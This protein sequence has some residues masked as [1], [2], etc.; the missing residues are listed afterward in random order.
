[1]INSIQN[2]EAVAGSDKKSPDTQCLLLIFDTRRMIY[3][4]HDLQTRIERYTLHITDI[5]G[6]TSLLVDV[7][8][9]RFMS[10]VRVIMGTYKKQDKGEKEK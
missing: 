10:R 9:G 8:T 2:T 4:R 6:K 1:M 7:R 5:T 3:R